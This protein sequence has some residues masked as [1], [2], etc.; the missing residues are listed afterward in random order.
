MS[1]PEK[2]DLHS[3]DI[4]KE[5]KEKLRE[6]FPEVFTEDKIDFEK[7]RQTLGE[8]VETG[9]ER[10]GMSWPGKA[11]CF[12]LIQSPSI[13]TLKPVREESVDFDTT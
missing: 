4:T 8:I 13:G 11:D 5:Q 12:K 2:L 1:E 3:M 9:K 10:Y 6:L 7:L